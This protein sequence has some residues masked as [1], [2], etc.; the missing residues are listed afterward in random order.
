VFSDLTTSSIVG[1][2][3]AIQNVNDVT[4]DFAASSFGET[5]FAT[6]NAIHEAS[7]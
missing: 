6:R 3:D 1:S 4:S 2:A 5:V 7:D